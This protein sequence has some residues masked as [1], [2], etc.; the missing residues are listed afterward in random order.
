MALQYLKIQYSAIFSTRGLILFLQV[1]TVLRIIGVLYVLG[2]T[3]LRARVSV[4]SQVIITETMTIKKERRMVAA[5][6]SGVLCTRK[7]PGA[8]ID[9]E[10]T[11]HLESRGAQ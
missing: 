6:L 3:L 8:R 7:Q 5:Q 9:L 4:D 10:F 11:L 1:H 2:S